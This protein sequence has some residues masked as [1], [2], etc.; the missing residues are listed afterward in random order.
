MVGAHLDSVPEGPG[1]N[2]N[3]SGA[4][5]VLAVAEA[6]GGTKTATA[7]ASPGG[8]PRSWA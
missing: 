3:A 6:L 8:A 5:A 2:D 4:A 7:C 1:M